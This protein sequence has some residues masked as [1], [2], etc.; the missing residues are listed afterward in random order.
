MNLTNKRKFKLSYNGLFFNKN[1]K[2]IEYYVTLVNGKITKLA[3][4]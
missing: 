1:N 3:I 4:F 2:F